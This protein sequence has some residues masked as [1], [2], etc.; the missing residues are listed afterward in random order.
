[1]KDPHNS[2]MVENLHPAVRGIF[3]AFIEE[4]ENDLALT[5]RIV[6]GLRTFAQQQAIYNQGRT[7]PDSIVTK[8]KPGQSYH[9]YGLAIDVV[10]VIKNGRELDWEY[11]FD[12]LEPSAIKYGITWGGTWKSP[13]RDHF[14]LTMGHNWRELLEKYNAKDFIQGTNYV[15][16]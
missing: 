11:D 9:N 4:A 10:P 16:L 1:M 6:Q 2:K 8:A 5:L 7:T 3:Q 14:E 15:N 12:K 13:D